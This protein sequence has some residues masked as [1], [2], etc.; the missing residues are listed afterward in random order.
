MEEDGLDTFFPPLPGGW[1][2][3][4]DVLPRGTAVGLEVFRCA[5]V[6]ADADAD[7]TT[8][9][10]VSWRHDVSAMSRTLRQRRSRLWRRHI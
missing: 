10:G 9:V 7:A 4:G 3:A 6:A 1:F 8:A 5:D 2:S